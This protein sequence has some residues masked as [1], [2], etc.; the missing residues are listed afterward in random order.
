MTSR[1]GE[2][3]NGV[4]QLGHFSEPILST[5]VWPM[6]FLTISPRLVSVLDGRFHACRFPCL[7]SS[8]LSRYIAGSLPKVA[9]SLMLHA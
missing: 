9:P 4:D 8:L 1:L 3:Q 5:R 6:R 2:Q 7:A